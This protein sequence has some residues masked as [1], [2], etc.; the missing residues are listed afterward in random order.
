MNN[1]ILQFNFKEGLMRK[2]ICGYKHAARKM[3]GTQ[4]TGGAREGMDS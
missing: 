2:F 3:P 1:P 4:G